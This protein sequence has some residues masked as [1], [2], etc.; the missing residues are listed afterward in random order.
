MKR[1]ISLFLMIIALSFTISCSSAWEPS[2]TD[3][4]RL[5]KNHYLFS[6]SGKVIDAEIAA[7]GDFNRDCKCF[8]L[9][10]RIKSNGEESFEKT[11]YFFKNE[12]GNVDV[13]EYQFTLNK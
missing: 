7:R 10:F 6:M 5:I 1:S 13:T 8:P 4:V 9:K 2:D 12:S 11:F 3:A